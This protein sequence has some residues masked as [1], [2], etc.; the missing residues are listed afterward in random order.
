MTPA[1]IKTLIKYDF[2]RHKGLDLK[3]SGVQYTVIRTLDH[4]VKKIELKDLNGQP[5]KED[6]T[7]A[8]GLNDYISGTYKFTHRDPGKSLMVGVT[9][10]LIKYLKEGKD[11]CKGID[12][13]RTYEQIVIED[14][15]NLTR[16]AKTQVEIS[17]E[18]NPFSGSTTAG[19]LAADAIRGSTGA[20]IAAYPSYLSKQGLII[21]ASSPFFREYIPNLYQFSHKNKVVTGQIRGRDLIQFLSKRNRNRRNP[22]L[23]VSGITCTIYLDPGGNVTSVDCNLPGKGK[24]SDSTLYTVSFNDYE[25]KNYY[26]LEAKVLHRSLSEQTVEQMLIDYIK[27]KGTISSRVKEKRIKIIQK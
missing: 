5:I 20:D 24:I 13:L 11:V 19:N 4:N 22:D 21:P 7:Y 2:E 16:I 14:T 18:E 25:F 26:K 23:Q 6:K 17:A 12:S 15:A 3:V 27:K 8:V 9:D 1:E 10:A